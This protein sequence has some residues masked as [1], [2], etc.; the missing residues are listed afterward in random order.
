MSEALVASSSESR[1]RRHQVTSPAAIA[2]RRP[3]TELLLAEEEID[4]PAAADV[5]S[6][7]VVTVGQGLGGISL[8]KTPCAIHL[9]RGGFTIYVPLDGLNSQPT[10]FVEE[11]MPN[12]AHTR[13][14]IEP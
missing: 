12:P 2:Q 7:R 14:A 13:T 1:R 6:S 9:I 11:Q 10:T 3:D 8:G 4:G 5:F